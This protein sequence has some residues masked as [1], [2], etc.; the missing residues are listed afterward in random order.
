M[1]SASCILEEITKRCFDVWRMNRIELD[2]GRHKESSAGSVPF[3]CAFIGE[4]ECFCGACIS[5]SINERRWPSSMNGKKYFF[6]WKRFYFREEIWKFFV[7]RNVFRALT[8]N[9]K[10]WREH[11]LVFFGE[12]SESFFKLFFRWKACICKAS[13]VFSTELKK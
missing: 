5:H 13:G 1:S 6:T 12:I 8:W 11:F 3:L 7:H 10:G 4:R 9:W 2:H